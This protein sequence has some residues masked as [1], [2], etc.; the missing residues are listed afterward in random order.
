MFR[1]NIVSLC[2]ILSKQFQLN[3]GE[4]VRLRL[5][6]GRYSDPFLSWFPFHLLPTSISQATSHHP[7]HE[8]RCEKLFMPIWNIF[9]QLF[10]ELDTTQR[11]SWSSFNT[12]LKTG[13]INISF[14]S[15]IRRS[16]NLS[17]KS[18]AETFRKTILSVPQGLQ[19]FP[20]PFKTLKQIA[21]IGATSQSQKVD[22]NIN[23]WPDILLQKNYCYIWDYLGIYRHIFIC[24]EA[25][26]IVRWSTWLFD[27]ISV[28][29][30]HHLLNLKWDFQKVEIWQ[31]WWHRCKLV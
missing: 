12:L 8:I 1:R 19:F 27:C 2:F 11:L 17:C 18:G 6:G 4:S 15:C 28:H 25:F 30:F 9:W 29:N 23:I 26:E 21:K 3:C 16:F 13:S 24:I 22:G 31:H 10:L 14:L 5:G 20:P 7:R